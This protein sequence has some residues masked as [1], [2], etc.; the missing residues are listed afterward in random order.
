MAGKKGAPYG[1]KNAVGRHSGMLGGVGTGLMFGATPGIG[2]LGG[3]ASSGIV[4]AGNKMAGKAGS[5]T[6]VRNFR[7]GNALGSAIQG[8]LAGGI[9]G[10]A[11]GALAGAV[12]STILSSISTKAGSY[13]GEKAASAYM[14]RKKR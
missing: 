5:P 9:I 11:P 8:G 1:N 12:G 14:K 2:A 13:V 3:F 10:G 7:R 6:L 4:G